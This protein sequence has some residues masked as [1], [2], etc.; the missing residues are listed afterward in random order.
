MGLILFTMALVA[1]IALCYIAIS[2]VH[3]DNYEGGQP[4][5][6]VGSGVVSGGLYV[7]ASPA[8]FGPTS[9]TKAFSLPAA[10][11]AQPGRIVWARLYVSVYCGHM[12]NNYVAM[13]AVSLDGDGDG[14]YDTV[15]DQLLQSLERSYI[16]AALR[17]T[18]GNVSQAAKIL[19]VNRTTLYS[20]MEASEAQDG[21]PAPIPE[22]KK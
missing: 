21:L 14:T 10:A 6:T 7:D 11:V 3:A 20:R 19:G 15:L 5:T 13:A 17:L 2:P 12:Q 4:L 18:R 22:K 16:N 1:V 8:S 9:V